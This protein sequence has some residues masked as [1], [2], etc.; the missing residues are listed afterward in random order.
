MPLHGV[1]GHHCRMTRLHADEAARQ[2]I[3][4][5][6][7]VEERVAL[8]LR[9]A[10][11]RQWWTLYLDDDDVQLP[12]L[13]PMAGYPERPDLPSGEGGT[14]AQLIAD[15]L[16]SIVRQVGAAKV[17]FVWERPGGAEATRGDV[18]W[19]RALAEACRAEGV[20]VRAQLILHSGGVRWFAADD[21]A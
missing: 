12:L 2:P 1:A 10:I 19:A 4:T 13:M 9:N 15:R 5:D 7:E 16:S 8:L 3:T 14:A 17:V 18:E 6:R 20:A 21:F 11:R